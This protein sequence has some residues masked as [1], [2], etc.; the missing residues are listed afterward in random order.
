[1]RRENYRLCG[2]EVK[3][4]LGQDNCPP[5]PVSPSG[6]RHSL[7]CIPGLCMRAKSLPLCLTLCD[8]LDC[9]PPRLLCPWDFPGKNTGVGC[10]ALLQ[11]S[12]LRLLCLLH[13]QVDSLPL[14]PP[15]RPT[16]VLQRVNSGMITGGPHYGRSNECMALGAGSPSLSFRAQGRGQAGPSPCGCKSA[17]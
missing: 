14:A 15:G 5:Q 7:T 12:R 1:M 4:Y 10:H 16:R 2:Q 17:R 13:W 8:P 3:C 11:G 9:S 6:H